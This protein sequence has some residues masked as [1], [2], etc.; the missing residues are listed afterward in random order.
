L[1]GLDADVGVFHVQCGEEPPGYVVVKGFGD[2]PKIHGVFFVALV[3]DKAVHLGRE[4]FHDYH[5][6]LAGGTVLWITTLVMR[7]SLE[8][9]L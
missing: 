4:R 5:M 7:A 3:H 6:A 2:K 8:S 9:E 1:V